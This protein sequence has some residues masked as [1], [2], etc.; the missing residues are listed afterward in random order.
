MI[1]TT[2]SA[3]PPMPATGDNYEVTDWPDGDS[4]VEAAPIDPWEV[5]Y[6]LGPN[7]EPVPAATT[8]ALERVER[9]RLSAKEFADHL[10][11]ADALLDRIA[12]KRGVL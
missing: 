6:G 1:E 11:R 10:E 9:L 4:D 5:R 12:A 3:P 8:D 7:A 2:R